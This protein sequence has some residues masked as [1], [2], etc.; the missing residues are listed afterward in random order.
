[1]RGAERVRPRVE[2]F[3]T[4]LEEGLRSQ[5]WS[6]FD[7]ASGGVAVEQ[8]V[9]RART[10]EQFNMRALAITG[11][12][13]PVVASEPDAVPLLMALF[14]TMQLL[15]TRVIAAYNHHL[16]EDAREL[17]DI[18]TLFLRIAGH[19]LRAP[20]TVI[21]GYA[22]MAID[23]ALGPVPDQLAAPIVTIQKSAARALNMLD[24]VVE[25]ARLE[26]R[27]EAVRREQCSLRELLDA[28]VEPY[29]EPA[30]EQNVRL[31]VEADDGSALLDRGQIVTAIGNLVA[32]AL[33]YGNAGRGLVTVTARRAGGDVVFEVADDGRGIET[34]ELSRLFERFHRSA[35]SQAS[36]IPGTGPGLY[37]VKR[38]TELHGGQVFVKSAPG[39]G[40]RFGMRI[41][42]AEGAAAADD[43]SM[44][45]DLSI[46]VVHLPAEEPEAPVTG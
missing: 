23:G 41:P 13:L 16:E 31:Q 10:P 27:S 37:I 17:D 12:L 39:A 3:L 46:T 29:R 43:G 8:L 34:D 45:S 6:R 32:N 5:D 2:L 35:V 42:A 22:S 19:D 18:K 36:G 14:D 25:T 15:G 1:V 11:T 24:R 4:L 9:R 26:S 30:R 40:S 38:I 33:R 7:E 44:P 28:A 21:A 20:L